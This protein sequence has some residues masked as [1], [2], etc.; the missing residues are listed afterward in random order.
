MET[1][2]NL[3]DRID[4]F[5]RDIHMDKMLKISSSDTKFLLIDF[6]ELDKYDFELA[7][8][9]IDNAEEVIKAF[10]EVLESFGIFGEAIRARFTNLPASYHFTIRDLRSTQLGNMIVLEGIIRQASEVRPEVM[11]TSWECPV[12]GNEIV[13]FQTGFTLEKP[14]E[15]VCG[16]RKGFILKNQDFSDVQ[17]INIEENPERLQGNEQPARLNIILRHDLVDP[18]FQKRVSPGNLVRVIG[19]LKETPIKG[20]DSKTYDI[21]LEA[22]YIDP[23]MFDF[24]EIAISMEDEEKIKDVASADP[25]KSI[26]VSIAPSIYGYEK[27]KEAIALQLFG[28]IRKKRPDGIWTRGDMHVLLIGD[29]GAGKSQLLK[30]VS[31]LAPKSRYVSGKGASAVGLTASVVKDEFLSGW[32]LEAG[33]LVLANGGIVCIDEMD[34]ISRDDVF[35]LHEAMEQQSITIAKANIFATLKSETSILAAANPKYGRFDLNAPIAEQISMPETILS[36]F[37]LIFPVK[38]IP[39]PEKDEK[40]AEHI[41]R[42]HK[43]PEAAKPLIERQFM[44]KYIAY[45]KKYVKPKLSDEALDAIK[46]FFVSLRAKYAGEASVPISP[47]QLEAL[48][49][50]TEASARL[51]LSPLATKE[52]AEKAI[53][54]LRYTLFQLAYDAETGKLD[55]DRLEGG[56]PAS[57]RSKIRI[58]IDI[59][60][61]LEKSEGKQVPRIKIIDMAMERE[62]SVDDA[63]KILDSLRMKGHIIEPK[64][65]YVERVD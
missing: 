34:K 27:I 57:K 35:A 42:L 30:Y 46:E 15:C 2:E 5:L 54:L 26:V 47:R 18:S 36:R 32:T 4:S 22:N 21:Y 6:S 25:W 49:R 24:E 12:C 28:G 10:D 13:Q 59:I 53:D 39:T 37:D 45:S 17:K 7:D 16:N 23:L 33:A 65:G 1:L 3:H 43:T 14:K 58:I 19:M 51:R 56:T 20:K 41:L 63:D 60:Q 8:H 50:M 40:L 48:V 44:K 52:D 31:E 9:L 61:E 29:P 62:M 38:D 64:Q 55:I 11:K